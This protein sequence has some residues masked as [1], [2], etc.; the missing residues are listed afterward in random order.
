MSSP[1]VPTPSP[2]NAPGMS[3]NAG[4][5]GCRA[6][7]IYVRHRT[8]SPGPLG[9]NTPDSPRMST[10]RPAEPWRRG[11]CCLKGGH[12]RTSPTRCCRTGSGLRSPF[13]HSDRPPP[14]ASP[15]RPSTHNASCGGHPAN[16]WNRQ[17]RR[18]GGFRFPPGRGRFAGR[19]RDR[20][21]ADAWSDNGIG[22]SILDSVPPS[23][24]CVWA[25]SRRGFGACFPA[26][27]P[28]QARV[29]ACGTGHGPQSVATWQLLQKRAGL[30]TAP[31]MTGRLKCGPVPRAPN[32]HP[33]RW[34]GLGRPVA[35]NLRRHF[36]V[37]PGDRSEH[38]GRPVRRSPPS[39]R[40]PA[41]SV[42]EVTL[43]LAPKWS[44]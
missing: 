6:V 42:D 20:A 21:W 3:R 8:H 28:F 11:R 4:A 43:S 9:G 44:C 16:P 1:W 18:S 40:G 15:S 5:R 10:D 7:Q 30:G 17:A 39:R 33:R 41:S 2:S 29:T 24:G 34:D 38:P 13:V 26:C 37:D 31:L 35:L 23:A 12:L 14:F 36:L 19:R 32:V 27:R 22:G 25:S